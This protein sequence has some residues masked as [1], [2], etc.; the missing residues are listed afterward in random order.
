MNKLLRMLK[1]TKVDMRVYA[2]ENRYL[3]VI[4]RKSHRS[5]RRI[6]DL[7]E[8]LNLKLDMED[9]IIEELKKFLLDPEVKILVQFGV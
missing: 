3:H 1:D 8:Q 6:F 9:L 7:D 4:F 5:Y 2:D